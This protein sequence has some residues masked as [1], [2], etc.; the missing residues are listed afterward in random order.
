[1]MMAIN[2]PTPRTANK[3]I[4][5]MEREGAAERAANGNGPPSTSGVGGSS[6]FQFGSFIESPSNGLTPKFANF[7]ADGGDGDGANGGPIQIQWEADLPTPNG[8]FL[9]T[10]PG[11]TASFMVGDSPTMG[12]GRLRLGVMELQ[13]PMAT[14]NPLGSATGSGPIFNFNG[15]LN[16]RAFGGNSGLGQLSQSAAMMDA[17]HWGGGTPAAGT[18]INAN[19]N[20]SAA[21]PATGRPAAGGGGAGGGG[22]AAAAAATTAAAAAGGSESR[23]R[24]SSEK[25]NGH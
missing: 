3:I 2:M 8:S 7:A 4:A 9:Q 14:T 21:A 16:P 25:G 19:N 17:A 12:G 15:S 1:M 5:N 11:S 22:G 10:T 6:T 23:N 13:S 18:P 24:T 20:T